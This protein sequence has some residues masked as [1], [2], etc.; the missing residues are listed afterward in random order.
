MGPTAI[1]SLLTF[2][3]VGNL[4][5]NAPYYAILLCFLAG[6]VE[7]LMGSLGLGKCTN[8]VLRCQSFLYYLLPLSCVDESVVYTVSLKTD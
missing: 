3:Q 4:G 8:F 5:T 6:C 7:L 1:V 2:Q